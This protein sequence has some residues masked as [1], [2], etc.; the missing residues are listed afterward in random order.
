MDGTGPKIV[1]SL[2]PKIM[3]SIPPTSVIAA[4]EVPGSPILKEAKA[5]PCAVVIFG[6]TGD[7]SKRK[8]VPALYNLMADGALPDKIAVVGLTRAGVAHDEMR[9]RFRE[10]TEQLGRRK[11][12][13]PD[14]WARFAA[15]LEFVDGKLDDDK[16]Y[17][18]LRERLAVIDREKG[19]HGNR[20]YYLATPPETFPAIL[21]HLKKA[22][23]LYPP[24]EDNKKKPWSRVVIEKPFGRDL[25]SAKALNKLV[26]ESLDESQTFRIDH[27][28]G[29]ETVQNILVFRYA[30]ALFEPVWDRKH[31]DHVEI[32]AAESLGVEKRGKFYDETGVVRDIVQNH[33]LQVL[34]LVAME[35][36]VSF[37]A[38]DVR[39]EKVQVLRSLRPITGS[40]MKKNVVRAQY[41]G[42]R[43]EDGVS[44]DSRTPTYTAMKVLI[45]NWRWQDVPFYLRAGKK[46]AHQ[47]TEVSI[48]FQPVPLYLFKQSKARQIVEP[49]VLTLRIQPQ[50]S[51]SLRFV[52]KVPGEHLSVGN[53][54]MNMSYADTFGKALSEAYE[55]LLLD[56]MRGDAT[57][58][59]RRDE[60]EEAWRFVTPILEHW[61][62]DPTP[63]PS[64][65]P[66][67]HGP[68]EADALLA[69]DGR[70]FTKL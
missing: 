68:K 8:L 39:D 23:L 42:Y 6:I 49:N 34:A 27:Y 35:P 63:M 57:L 47:V 18:D 11:A 15:N 10:S 44:A 7:L 48:H 28:L 31:I 20:I 64:Y 33:L 69:A 3:E 67:T 36:P 22:E 52:T 59:A 13:D 55:R 50:E 19:T 21:E 61:D 29:K 41:A 26:A 25:A 9:E 5:D 4:E 58:F 40:D 24:T 51:I 70:C 43:G 56:C 45:D 14:I 54:L 46:L 32:T 53:V 38:N 17:A 2:R 16:A 60:V 1:D 37:R 65:E 30:N 62:K 66:G 12:I